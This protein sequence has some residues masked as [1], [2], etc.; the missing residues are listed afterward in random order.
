MTEEPVEQ[1]ALIFLTEEFPPF[2]YEEEGELKGIGVELLKAAY[3][4]MGFSLPDDAIRIGLFTEGYQTT[5]STPGYVLFS[6]ARRPEREDQFLWAG[7]IASTT[8]VLFSRR[9][10]EITV[11]DERDLNQYKIGAVEDDVSVLELKRAGVDEDQIV[12]DP[13]PINLIRMLDRGEI[14]LYASGDL[15]G[16]YLIAKAT[17]KYGYFNQVYRLTEVDIY[18]AFNK[19]TPKREIE[20]F[21]SAIDALKETPADGGL[22][23]Y[24]RILNRYMP[25]KGLA[26]L[27]YM[28][29]EYYPYN[30]LEDGV[31]QGI[32]VDIIEEIFTD[33]NTD[34]SRDQV[35]LST[36]EDGY[37]K[38]LS[39]PGYVLF[40]TA[41]TPEREDLFLWAGPIV[42]SRNVLFMRAG[43][44]VQ[45][46][47]DIFKLSVG[48]ITDDVAGDDLRLLGYDKIK[49]ATGAEELIQALEAGEI[50]AWAYAEYPGI[51]LIGMHAQHPEA[52]IIAYPLTMH[53]YYVTF[54]RETPEPL[55]QA[56]QQALDR[57][58]S[59]KDA[60]GVSRYERTL[61]RYLTPGYA[62]DLLTEEDAVGLVSRTA[63]AL[64][65]DAPATIR[66]IKAGRHPYRD[67]QKP[68]LY[69]F[70]Y[71]TDVV[72]VA[73][74]TNIHLV[75]VS[76][77]GK[78]D[79]TGEA[80]QDMMVEGALE[81]GFGWEDYVSLN[82]AESGLFWKR[83]YYQLA[84]GSDGKEYVVCSGIFKTE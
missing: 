50:D 33:L 23:G 37:Q 81:N 74:A 71:D 7:P 51:R 49:Y 63:D 43:E 46:V 13:D 80:F 72:M 34:L 75:G 52:I 45:T 3:E 70:V 78:T 41:R 29:E 5:R 6:T 53:E 79:V 39:I 9:G 61:Y 44:S 28:T 8:I 24:N 20:W 18:Y 19:E 32:S 30:F 25:S 31:V 16:E 57:I 22:S 54:N 35:F 27:T 14:D 40:S 11:A 1:P 76:F 64:A 38:T 17:G 62:T 10:S 15:A 56:F 82:P 83:T 47:D 60:F 66:A 69:V 73:D 42:R 84:I 65:D 77:K 36:W 4:E 21:Q 68:G 2:N 48:A 55:I 67:E 26:T 12:T 58:Q 59:E